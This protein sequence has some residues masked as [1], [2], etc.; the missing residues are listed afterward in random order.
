[1]AENEELYLVLSKRQTI[2]EEE[3][4]GDGPTAGDTQVTDHI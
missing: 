2:I 1:M 3:D 4:P